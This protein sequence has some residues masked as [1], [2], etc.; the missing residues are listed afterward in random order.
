[1]TVS[2]RTP[3]GWSGRCTTCGNKL[4]VEPSATGHDAT[5]PRCG[6]L[7]WLHPP[8]PVA[9]RI[10]RFGCLAALVLSVAGGVLIGWSVELGRIDLA[11]LGLLGVLLFS[12]YV[13]WASEASQV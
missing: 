5:C 2:T 6:A 7:V 9:A 12:R 13:R 1:M 3:E 10:A 8:V 4:R 11:M